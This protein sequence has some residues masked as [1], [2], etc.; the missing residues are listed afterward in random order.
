MSSVGM[1]WSRKRSPPLSPVAVRRCL[2][3]LARQPARQ[4]A[5]RPA[6]HAERCSATGR[7]TIARPGR[8]GRRPAAARRPQLQQ[9]RHAGTSPPVVLSAHDP[10]RSVRKSVQWLDRIDNTRSKWL[11][12]M[13]DL[14]RHQSRAGLPAPGTGEL[15]DKGLPTWHKRGTWQERH[16]VVGDVLRLVAHHRA[17]ANG[18]RWLAGT[19]CWPRLRLNHNS[20]RY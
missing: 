11:I 15:P 14:V 20:F 16:I 5:R 9:A 6:R 3:Q 19:I 12:A 17:G 7:L 8:T 1:E 10:W 18:Y 2:F 4:P 13:S